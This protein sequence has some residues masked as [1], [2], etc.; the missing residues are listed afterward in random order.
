[1]EFQIAPCRA[2]DVKV[3]DL[4]AALDPASGPQTCLVMHVCHEDDTVRLSFVGCLGGALTD[5]DADDGEIVADAIGVL[6]RLE[7]VS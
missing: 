5:G 1:M 6:A 7:A 2:M 4:L 3:G